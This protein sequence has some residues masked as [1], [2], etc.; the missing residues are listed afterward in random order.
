MARKKRKTP[1]I[2]PEKV[3]ASTTPEEQTVT[4]EEPVLPTTPEEKEPEINEQTTEEPL[5]IINEESLPEIVT[6]EIVN[7]MV[8]VQVI[9]GSVGVL[10]LG[11]YEAG[12]TFIL[13]KERAKQLD[14]RFIKIV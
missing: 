5:P 1:I 13:S 12:D 10:G 6:D 14:P 8:K 11:N 7:G 9:Y 4:L 3:E 2:E